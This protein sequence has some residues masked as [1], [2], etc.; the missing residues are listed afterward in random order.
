MVQSGN[1]P[2]YQLVF[3]VKKIEASLAFCT[4][5]PTEQ[6]TPPARSE[7]NEMRLHVQLD[8]Y[9]EKEFWVLTKQ[10]NRAFLYDN[11]PPRAEV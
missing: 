5:A 10:T 4:A 7:P 2:Y 9:A 6:T 1:L 11:N 8:L 3:W